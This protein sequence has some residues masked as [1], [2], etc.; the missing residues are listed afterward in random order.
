M[1]ISC[2]IFYWSSPGARL[3][4]SDSVQPVPLLSHGVRPADPQLDYQPRIAYHETQISIF[5]MLNLNT[6]EKIKQR[7]A[8]ASVY[9]EDIQES[10]VLGSGPGG[11][12]TNKTYSTVRLYHEP[13]DLTIKYGAS[14]SREANRWLARRLLAE[15]ILERDQSELSARKQAIAKIRRQKRRRSRRQKER[16]LAAKRM[17]SEKKDARKPIDPHSE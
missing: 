2:T 6:I 10:F 17:H 9:E 4:I 5:N 13:S 7:M 11:Q 8:L 14:R 1:C 3:R 16:I 15:K 12:K